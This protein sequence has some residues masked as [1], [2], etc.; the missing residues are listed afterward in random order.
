MSNKLIA[1]NRKAYHDYFIEEKIE[2]GIEL[3]GTEVKSIRAGK[4]SIKEAWCS[5][6][7]NEILINGMHISKYEQGNIFNHDELRLK[8]LL[9]HKWEISKLARITDIQGYTLVPVDVYLNEQGRVKIAIGVCK[10]KHNY[11]KREALKEKD[12]K[13]DISRALRGKEV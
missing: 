6:V 10:G 4:C 13:R 1:Q 2:C 9:V 5:I 11:D 8:K 7:N 3:K 12:T